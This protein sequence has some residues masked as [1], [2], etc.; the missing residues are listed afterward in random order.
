MAQRSKF[1]DPGFILAIVVLVYSAFVWIWWPSETYV[2]GV[3]LTAWLMLIG[4]I[5]WFGLAIIYVLWIEHIEKSVKEQ[6]ERR[7]TYENY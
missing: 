6:T 5:L 1:K 3:A 4:I 7:D 2:A